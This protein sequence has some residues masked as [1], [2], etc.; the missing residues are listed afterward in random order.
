MRGPTRSARTGRTLARNQAYAVCGW[1]PW[2]IAHSF[3]FMPEKMRRNDSPNRTRPNTTHQHRKQLPTPRWSPASAELAGAPA[4]S[5]ATNRAHA[6]PGDPLS[7]E[8]RGHRAGDLAA[9]GRLFD[10]QNR[11]AD[12][13]FRHRAVA[14]GVE[15]DARMADRPGMDRIPMDAHEPLVGAEGMIGDG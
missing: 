1:T 4:R 8:E 6:A 7:A 3:S 15:A 5:E 9:D 14:C 10:D 11:S 2:A 12:R 13:Q